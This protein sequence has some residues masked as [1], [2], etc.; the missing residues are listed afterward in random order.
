MIHLQ[1]VPLSMMYFHRLRNIAYL[2]FILALVSVFA[3]PLPSSVIRKSIEHPAVKHKVT[4]VLVRFPGKVQRDSESKS[5]HK[6]SDESIER[7]S[8]EF[9][10]S[11]IRYQFELGKLNEV[12]FRFSGYPLEP[13]DG[14]MYILEEVTLMLD[15]VAEKVWKCKG[16]VGLK[17]PEPRQSTFTG[18]TLTDMHLN[19]VIAQMYGHNFEKSLYNEYH[20]S[21]PAYLLQ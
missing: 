12:D 18:G 20:H 15:P 17:Q 5:L 11:V 8:R 21:L 6:F 16:E 7:A 2:V 13:N 14:G 10:K 19:A 4:Q 1:A 9:L 3:V